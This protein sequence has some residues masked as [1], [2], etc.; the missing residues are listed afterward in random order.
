MEEGNQR[1][2]VTRFLAGRWTMTCATDSPGSAV[3]PLVQSRRQPPRCP[4]AATGQRRLCVRGR[5]SGP[6]EIAPGGVL[7]GQPC[8]RHRPMML[9]DPNRPDDWRA[10][11]ANLVGRRRPSQHRRSPPRLPSG[12]RPQR[13]GSVSVARKA[14]RLHDFAVQ[15]RAAMC[16]FM[17]PLRRVRERPTSGTGCRGRRAAPRRVRPGARGPPGG[18]PC[19]RPPALRP[20]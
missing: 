13:W 10:K 19:G 14:C 15:A 1:S 5:W 4:D 17:T 7:T 3:L 2:P 12:H 20:G 16:T 6:D 9:R 8:C 11:I 18:P